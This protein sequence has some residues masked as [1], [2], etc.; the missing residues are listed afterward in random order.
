[1]SMWKVALGA[2]GRVLP[3]LRPEWSRTWM[4]GRLAVEGKLEAGAFGDLGRTL[5][6][7][8]DLDHAL[9]AVDQLEGLGH[10]LA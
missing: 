7:E 2:T 9:L 6:V 10:D 1:M 3:V 8:G 5:L 4:V